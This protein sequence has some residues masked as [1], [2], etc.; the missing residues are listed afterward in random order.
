[1]ARKNTRLYSLDAV[2]TYLAKLDHG[3]GIQLDVIEGTLLD[4]IIIWHGG[5]TYEVFEEVAVNSWNSAYAR[6]VYRHG[7]PQEW[8]DALDAELDRLDAEDAA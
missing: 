6:H 8:I 2:E 4:T 7:L 1:M 5:E 3:D